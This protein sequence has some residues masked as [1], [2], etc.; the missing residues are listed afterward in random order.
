MFFERIQKAEYNFGMEEV[1]QFWDCRQECL[2]E[3]LLLECNPNDPGLVPEKQNHY[4]ETGEV[5]MMSKKWPE[6]D[7][8]FDRRIWAKSL[9]L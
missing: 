4:R 2:P 9:F 1:A 6:F 7:N 5:I 8:S 3:H